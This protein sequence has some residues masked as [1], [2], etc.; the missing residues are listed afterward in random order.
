MARRK[1]KV[2]KS[3]VARLAA[4]GVLSG[5]GGVAIYQSQ[6]SKP[7]N[8]VAEQDQDDDGQASDEDENSGSGGGDGS[9]GDG[10]GGDDS[11]SGGDGSASSL[12]IGGQESQASSGGTGDSLTAPSRSNRIMPSAQPGQ[13]STRAPSISINDQGS[14]SPS[15]G[16]GLSMPSSRPPGSPPG[17]PTGSSARPSSGLAM[18]GANPSSTERP[19]AGPG[20]TED[21]LTVTRPG[22]TPPPTRSVSMTDQNPAT[23]PD[24]SDPI[25]PPP[26]GGASS[27]LAM[28]GTSP[29]TSPGTSPP[30]QPDPRNLLSSESSDTA[31]R[32]GDGLTPPLPGVNDL[33]GTG[34][35]ADSGSPR[36]P[37]GTLASVNDTPNP[38]EQAPNLRVPGADSQASD[39]GSLARDGL[40][41]G[42]AVAGAGA[43]I[44]ATQDTPSLSQPPSLPSTSPPSTSLSDIPSRQPG[45]GAGTNL[46]NPNGPPSGL[47]NPSLSSTGS[48]VG[49]SG[50]TGA[51]AGAPG[52]SPASNLNVPSMQTGAA[53]PLGPPNTATQGRGA[54]PNNRAMAN[55]YATTNSTTP[56]TRLN[57]NPSS[58]TPSRYPANGSGYAS[59][60]NLSQG[61]DPY[62]GN[63]Y[64]STPQ[65][66]ASAVSDTPGGIELDGA[67]SP[68]L[69]MEK[70]APREIQVGRL[71]TF[72]T[73]IQN[74]GPTEAV[75]VIVTDRIPAGTR[76]ESVT[77]EPISNS[78]GLLVWN[79]GSIKSGRAQTITMNL[80][81]E[82]RGEIGSVAQVTFNAKVGVRTVCTQ[83]KLEID[84]EAPEKV[85]IG[86]DVVLRINIV[87]NGDGAASNVIIEEDV[88]DGVSHPE[89]REIQYPL[90]NLGPGERRQLAL[91]L[92]AEQA[93]K[94]RNIISVRGD[95]NA[96]DESQTEFEVIAPSLQV[97]MSG[98]RKRYLERTTIHQIRIEN[99]G[100]APATR[101]EIVAQL[102]KG[103]K[104][105]ETNNHGTYDPATHSVYW[106]LE[107]LPEGTVDDSIQLVTL[108]VEPGDQHIDYQAT[109]DLNLA[110]SRRQSIEVVQLAELFFDIDDVADPIEVNGETMYHL[111][112]TNQGSKV[113]TQV[114]LMVEFPA[115]LQPTSAEGPIKHTLRDQ[116]VFFDPIERIA[117]GEEVQLK[118]H[119]RGLQ[120]GDHRVVVSLTSDDNSSPVVK[121]ASTNVYVDR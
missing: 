63:R 81:P 77:P 83:P 113:A 41:A 106:G 18:P 119:A 82:R 4:I 42:A 54:T 15:G 52:T 1:F 117:P 112:V 34:S 43:L 91:T 88:P 26:S 74:V 17:S 96:F 111:R 64:S 73:V 67:Q 55:P 105:Q 31:A 97:T 6:Q 45:G 56:S 90:G 94:V 85:L 27:G 78:G 86:Q 66:N 21:S 93:S 48:Q 107:S 36:N 53:D 5:M 116:T 121:Q 30:T 120:A 79:L 72:E 7:E 76:L 25:G 9:G 104:F 68:S 61:S 8:T 58:Q 87:N 69:A 70:R 50:R 98:P 37:S 40:R 39:S 102:P 19:G 49:G 118:L 89:G 110:D 10:S 92:R 16:G 99:R 65:V 38:A 35:A 103:L 60:G 29:S 46:A 71:A 84:V 47:S 75:D 51:G 62:G 100:T 57:D 14:G 33:R 28:P 23:G 108:P 44:A 114:R 59:S 24:G 80:V 11:E 95:D 2:S 32:N 115:A 101:V 20:G 3:I 22:T 109:A 12:R 13:P